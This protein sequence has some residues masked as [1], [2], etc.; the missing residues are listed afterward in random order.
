VVGDSYKIFAI[1]YGHHERRSSENFLGGDLHDV[2]MPLD[3]FVWA[4]VGEARTVILDTGFDRP[5]AAK[6][7]R[8]VVRP[9]EEGL[10]IIGIDHAA[11]TDVII[12]HMHY[13]HCGNHS[14][15]PNATFHLQDCEM[16]YATGRCMCHEVMRHPFDVDDVT[17][18]VRRLHGGKLAFHDGNEEL[19]PG[20]GL[21][22]VG[23]HSRGLQV[24]RV[25]TDRGA[26]VLGSDAAHFYAN[27]ERNRPFPV[28]E[29][30]GA[31]LEGVRRMRSLASSD[32][33]IIPGHDPLVVVRYPKAVAGIEDIVRLD[34]TPKAH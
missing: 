1:R 27:I 14:L 5:M 28:L 4:I 9:V 13:D 2:D 19:A 8:H 26:V 34:L 31:A 21:H 20:I 23:G 17:T 29:N 33:H 10:A 12:S 30:V 11:V 24:V 6:R 7:G 15:F 22:L 32:D 3:Y 25:T 16:E 18:M